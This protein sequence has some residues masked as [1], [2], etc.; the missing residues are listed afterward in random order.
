MD[1]AASLAT[2]RRTVEKLGALS[3]TCCF[4]SARI[5]LASAESFSNST[6]RLRRRPKMRSTRAAEDGLPSLLDQMFA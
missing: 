2:C 3:F 5:A 6:P 4:H 1:A